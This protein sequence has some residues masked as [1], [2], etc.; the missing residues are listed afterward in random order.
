MPRRNVA[1]G[2][3]LD[4]TVFTKLP[5]I[6]DEEDE[7][8]FING[9]RTDVWDKSLGYYSDEEQY[10]CELDTNDQQSELETNKNGTCGA[11][12]QS[13]DGLEDDHIDG[14]LQV[15]VTLTNE[16]FNA[17]GKLGNGIVG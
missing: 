13:P 15:P 2:I 16:E 14:S 5:T 3:P 9:N 12:V 4:D 1:I 17:P 7:E 10:D 11:L 8:V 6:Y